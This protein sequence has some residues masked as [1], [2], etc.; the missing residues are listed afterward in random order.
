MRAF[1]IEDIAKVIEAALLCAK[2]S[3]GGD[4]SQANSQGK[5][6]WIVDLLALMKV[7]VIVR[8]LDKIGRIFCGERSTTLLSVS[9]T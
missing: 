1:V 6:A 8:Y 5:S 2:D 7:K 3:R 9:C 4:R